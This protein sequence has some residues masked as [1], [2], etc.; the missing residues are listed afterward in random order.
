[1]LAPEATRRGR[2]RGAVR[3][4][5]AVAGRHVGDGKPQ[6]PVAARIDAQPPQEDK[7]AVVR[8]GDFVRL[9]HRGEEDAQR[10]RAR[11]AGQAPSPPVR[12][13]TTVPGSASVVLNIRESEAR[14]Y[15]PGARLRPRQQ[16][17]WRA[18]T[19]ILTFVRA[20]KERNVQ[21]GRGVAEA[22]D[23]P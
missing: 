13:V 19:F 6:P 1:M 20:E 10:R 12:T 17:E 14:H 3:E 4:G 8:R 16:W 9:V 21:S 22:L 23:T 5:G 2:T 18:C 7:T 15:L 11:K